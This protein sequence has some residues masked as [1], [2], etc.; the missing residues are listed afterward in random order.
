MVVAVSGRTCELQPWKGED[1]ERESYEM[2][3][4]ESER[5][6]GEQ[7]R[8]KRKRREKRERRGVNESE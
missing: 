7:R 1:T 2:R 3:D 8:K 5:T 6:E 4:L